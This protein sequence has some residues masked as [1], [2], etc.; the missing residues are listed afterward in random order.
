MSRPATVAARRPTRRDRRA[1]TRS[2]LLD[3]AS[4]L[5]TRQGIQATTLEQIAT[6]AGFTRGAVYSNYTDKD[7]LVVALLDRR[8]ERS[9]AEVEEVFEQDH[10]PAAF[11][12]ALLE[13]AR[14]RA[15]IAEQVLWVEFWLYALRNR[16]VRPK[17]AARF[18]AR[19]RAVARVIELQFADMGVALPGDPEGMATSVLAMDEGLALHRLVDPAAHPDD[20]LYEA[21]WNMLHGAAALAREQSSIAEP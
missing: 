7:D 20:L 2:R 18:A 6:A 21:L 14:R 10:D 17:L 19:R 15:A 5:F 8:V 11:Y 13:R 3:A 9:I 1:E 16:R 4:T 12:A